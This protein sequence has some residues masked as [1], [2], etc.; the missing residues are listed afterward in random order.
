M[1]TRGV[2]NSGET[3][4]YAVG[5]S[6]GTQRGIHHVGH[7]GAFVGYRAATLR[8]PSEDL[9]IAVLC[10][11]ALT[12]PMGMALQVGEILLDS[13]MSS[14]EASGAEGSRPSGPR[15]EPAPPLSEDEMA[16]FVG[17]YYAREVDST[18]RIFRGERG[19]MVDVNGGWEF[20]LLP[21][22]TDRLHAVFLSLS[23]Y[24]EGGKIAGF[25]AESGRAGGVRFVRR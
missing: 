3:I 7:G 22:G 4:D 20:R 16:A 13:K 9:G 21:D 1:E 10:N 18:F 14:E 11:Y 8:Y 19:L 12:D 23:F 25:L 15:S 17:T 2:L 5:L 6:H 24:R